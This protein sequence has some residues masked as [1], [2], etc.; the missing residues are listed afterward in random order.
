MK[1][2]NDSDIAKMIGED[3]QPDDKET[4]KSVRKSLHLSTRIPK[5]SATIPEHITI[6]FHNHTE[7]EAW[8]MLVQVAD[9]ETRS[10]TVITGASGILKQKFQQWATDSIISHRI[11]SFTP[12]NNGSFSVRF[13]KTKKSN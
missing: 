9:S 7:Q 10:A 4:K 8:D 13:H 12:L 2:L 1:Q 5:P 11:I 6:D 3:F